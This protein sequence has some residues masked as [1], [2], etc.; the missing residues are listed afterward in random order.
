[1]FSEEKNLLAE[2]LIKRQGVNFE[3][4]TELI[5]FMKE[6]EPIIEEYK[7]EKSNLLAE[8]QVQKY[9]LL[10]ELLEKYQQMFN[11][12]ETKYEEKIQSDCQHPLWYLVYSTTNDYE[13]RTYWTCLCLEC[14]LREEDRSHRFSNVI[15]G[16][17]LFARA[18][19]HKKSYQTIQ[20]EYRI[21]LDKYDNYYQQKSLDDDLYNKNA[22]CKVLMKKM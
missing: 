17:C 11:E 6:I 1:M 21:L 10:E 15:T 14:G 16:T 12:L 5:A 4:D 22:V 19:R 13:G 20:R 8:E 7:M 2:K 18:E 9:I 3:N